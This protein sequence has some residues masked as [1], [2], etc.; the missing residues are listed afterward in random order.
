MLTSVGAGKGVGA[1][2]Q[3]LDLSDGQ[4]VHIARDTFGRGIRPLSGKTPSART[5]TWHL[6]KLTRKTA[7]STNGSFCSFDGV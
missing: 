2:D 7:Q 3:T 5:G 4:Q 6:A 1:E